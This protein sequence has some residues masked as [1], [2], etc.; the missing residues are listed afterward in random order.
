MPIIQK[1]NIL[2]EVHYLVWH[3]VENEHEL[4]RGLHLPKGDSAKIQG[5]TNVNRRREMLATRQ[6]LKVFFGE[7]MPEIAYLPNGCPV[8]NNGYHIS[9]SHTRNLAA[10]AVSKIHTV[11]IDIEIRRD[12]IARI[13]GKFVNEQE[14]K[15]V[16]TEGRSDYLLALWGAKE[17]VVKLTRNRRL[18]F[19]NAIQVS[20]FALRGKEGFTEVRYHNAEEHRAKL[21]FQRNDNY[22]LTLAYQ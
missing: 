3:I 12:R 13:A 1:S 4:W 10:I 19:K 17:C 16:P 20:P 8:L 7:Q 11:G 15:F 5:F 6:C 9:V 22:F 21:Y 2:K 14:E 18:D